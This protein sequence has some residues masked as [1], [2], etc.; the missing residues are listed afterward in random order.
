MMH[1]QG[2]RVPLVLFGHMHSQLKG[3]RAAVLMP[4]VAF[5]P[6]LACLLPL[7]AAP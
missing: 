4:T 7:L 3:G 6:Q 5:S 2:V 1:A